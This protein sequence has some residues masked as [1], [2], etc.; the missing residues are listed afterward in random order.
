MVGRS[1]VLLVM[2]VGVEYSIVS[3]DLIDLNFHKKLKKFTTYN[4]LFFLLKPF[5]LI[6]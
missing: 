5:S 2:G 1:A 3:T 4:L 6:I